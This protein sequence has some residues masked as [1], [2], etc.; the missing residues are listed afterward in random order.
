VVAF[1]PG[2]V[3]LIGDH[4]DYCGGGVLPM[5]IQYGTW[6][7]AAANGSD[8]IRA[9]SDNADATI[10][11][12]QDRQPT[13][14]TGHWGRFVAGA[15]AV[16][17]DC[18][19]PYRGMDL[20]IAGDIPGS[21]LSSSASLSVALLQAMG[22]LTDC[23]LQGLSLALAAQ[24]I[25]HRHIGVS[26]G[27]MD[28]AVV[29]LGQPDAALHFDC[30][31][32]EGRPIP[33]RPGQC[34]MVVADSGV[35]RTLASSAYNTRLDELARIGSALSLAPQTLA[36]ALKSAPALDDPVLTRRARHIVTEQARVDAACAALQ[37]GDWCGFGHLL[38]VSH[39]SLRDDY[40]VSCA[41]VDLLVEIF[42][43]QPGC[44]G[45]R[46]TGA[47]FGGAVVAAVNGAQAEACQ[48]A[49]AEEFAAQSGRRTNTFV[50]LSKGGARIYD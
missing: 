31:T 47:G 25:E 14:P 18:G 32:Q 42:A 1:A 35:P 7:A 38:Q 50:A 9:R 40:A 19:S 26:C 36:V 27:L 24:Q 39:A 43:R 6:V 4:I 8:E 30:V 48:R 44:Y 29:V 13:F 34:A 49:V 41:D 28:Q 3:N 11:L 46:M 37:E 22:A 16:L 21:G 10:R 5:P 33:L 2:R 45:A 17:R 23:R 20:L 12:T 15:D